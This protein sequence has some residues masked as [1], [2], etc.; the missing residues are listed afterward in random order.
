MSKDLSTPNPERFGLGSFSELLPARDPIIVEDPGSF[1]GFHDAMLT[2]LVPMTAYEAVVAENLI[3]IE[4]ELLQHRRMRDASIRRKMREAICGAVETKLEQQY[5]DRVDDAYN[6]F[7]EEGGDDEDWEDTVDFDEEAATQAGEDLAARAISHDPDL[8]R[9]AYAEIT[10][11]GYDPVELMS[12]AYRSGN[13][14][15]IRHDEK[16]QELERRRREVRRDY[17]ALQKARPIE[18]AIIEG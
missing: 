4:W 15:A 2:S 10:E 8:Q 5:N 13:L 17:D 9:A 3:A 16:I 11:L 18:G 1:A 12:E 14:P 7:I 6:R